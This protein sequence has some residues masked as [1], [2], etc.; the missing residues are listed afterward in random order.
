[1]RTI[2]LLRSAAA[3]L[4]LAA[5]STR[6]APAQ[7]YWFDEA[8][9][10]SVRLELLKPFLEDTDEG[11][12]TGAGFLGASAQV[13]PSLRFEGELPFARAAASGAGSALRMGNPYVGIR[14]HREGK[15]ASARLGVRLPLASLPGS[16]EALTADLVGASADV[17]RLEAF[18][19]KV[20]TIRGSVE[21]R[22]VNAGGLLLGASIGPT[23]LIST[24]DDVNES[25]ELLADYGV[26]VGYEGA[27]ALVTAAFTGRLLVTEEGL[28]IED[29]TTHQVTGMAELRSGRVRPSLLVRLPLDHSNR[30]VVPFIVGIGV[31]VAF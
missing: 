14:L 16:F 23:V 26:R 12:L 3:G 13:R 10:G 8:G 4:V 5:A 25:S 19:P 28:S 17:D 22:R 27:S 20:L 15:A 11:F 29:R 9:R 2:C 18:S 21:Y 6:A 30:E 1:M 7:A 24:D 31:R